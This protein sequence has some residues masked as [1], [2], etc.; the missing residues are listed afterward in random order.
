MKLS[1][2][3]TVYNQEE[4]IK[5][6]IESIPVNCEI[7]VID[8]ASSDNTAKVVKDYDVILIKNTENIGA[9]L[10]RN[11]GVEI[12]KGDY[13]AFLDSDDYF[14]TTKL[15]LVMKHMGDY[16]VIF[17][18]MIDN[19]NY[20]YVLNKDTHIKFCGMN[21]LIKRDFLGETRFLDKR[22]REDYFFTSELLSKNGNYLYTNEIVYV[23]NHPR[24]E[25]LTW[26]NQRGLI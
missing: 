5:R 26:K 14:D 6:A 2:I 4:L 9:G 18:N 17:Y 7:I 12:A 10:S 3:I 20:E 23:Y 24:K 16:D 1:V 15:K 13:I 22:V 11:K 21:K 25:S 19:E 8:D